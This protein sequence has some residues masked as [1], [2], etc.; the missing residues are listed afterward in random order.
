MAIR[1]D[2]IRAGRD[3]RPFLGP[4]LSAA[5]LFPVLSLPDSSSIDLSA[6]DGRGREERFHPRQRVGIPLKAPFPLSVFFFRSSLAGRVHEHVPRRLP[7]LP[8]T[9]VNPFLALGRVLESG[10]RR[11]SIFGADEFPLVV[12]APHPHGWTDG[13]MDVAPEFGRWFLASAVILQPDLRPLSST[14]QR[15]ALI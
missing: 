3:R 14:W 8:S 12:W 10:V 13:R 7:W 15:D 1:S 11:Q 4:H 5:T 2:P 9:A 6:A